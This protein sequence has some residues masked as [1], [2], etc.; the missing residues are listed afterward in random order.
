MRA[1]DLTI[2]DAERP[3]ML[4]WHLIKWRGWQL[5]LHKICRSDD[6]RALHD[7]RADNWSFILWGN[8]E[9][10]LAAGW[11]P[12]CTKNPAH[13]LHL[14]HFRHRFWPYFR[15]AELPHRLI[16]DKPVWTLWLRAPPRR[17]WGFWCPKRWV[18][19]L[20]FIGEDY[21]TS[22]TSPI[23]NGCDE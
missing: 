2:G 20:T 21:R 11:R 12:G 10:V 23:R 14:I 17:E 4:R 1:P 7:H 6:D 22:G 15:P 18:P 3:Y 8:Y 19:W 13:L 5:C 9:E 16:V